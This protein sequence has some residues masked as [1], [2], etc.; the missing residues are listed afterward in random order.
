MDNICHTLVGA[1]LGEAGLKHRTPLAMATLLVGAN[2]P[3]VDAFTYAFAAGPTALAFRRGWTHGVLAMAVLPV[4]LA[5]TMVAWDR[6]VRR[7]RRPDAP[8]ARWGPLLLL[9]YV[10]VLSHPLLD[11]LNT[12]GV[13]FLHPFSNRWFYGDA[14]FIV[15]PWVWS[16]LA[17]GIAFASFRR[18]RGAPRVE[19][20]ARV[21]IAAVLVYAA[22]MLAS[23]AAGRAVVRGAAE[24]AGV[25]VKRVL[26]APL[27]LD[28][29]R[30]MVLVEEPRA[31]RFG[32]LD[33]LP[34]PS[35]SFAPVA[36]PTNDDD[37][38]CA[39]AVATPDGRKFMVWS[40]FP[41][42]N[43][44]RGGGETYVTIT[45]ARYRGPTG[46]WAQVTVAVPEESRPD[47]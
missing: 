25:A 18:R 29:F 35:V 14:L 12:Y 6:S 2:L 21:A 16:A 27:P 42:F 44:R 5:G 23:S 38:A 37:P 24:R 15:D 1:A 20:P 22:A 30:R 43:V 19:A 26:V 17:L 36:L 32:T 4:V 47:R 13:R 9:A 33:W 3:D 41:Y 7:R 10:S 46:S 40:R 28:P 45:D 39:A 8:A 31:Y 34:G 11:F